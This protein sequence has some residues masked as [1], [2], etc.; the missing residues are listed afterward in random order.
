MPL[1]PQ[2]FVTKWKRVTAREKQVYQERFI[3]LC[4][5]VD[6]HTP[7]D[8]DPTGMPSLLKWEQP[9]PAVDRAGRTQPNW[10]SLAGNTRARIMNRTKPTS[11]FCFIGMH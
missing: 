8:Y 9:K 5:L 7:N 2:E 6:H 4:R 10:V 3:D 1:T 11:I